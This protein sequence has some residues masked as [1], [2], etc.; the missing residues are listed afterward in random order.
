MQVGARVAGAE[1]RGK[2]V[3]WKAGWEEGTRG[4]RKK[5]KEKMEEE[6]EDEVVEK[7]KIY[8]RRSGGNESGREKGETEMIEAVIVDERERGK[9]EED[10]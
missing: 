1:R 7:D 10:G 8:G 9:W 2:K 4:E 3:S 6:E 5:G